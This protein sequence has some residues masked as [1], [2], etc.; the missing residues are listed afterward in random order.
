MGAAEEQAGEFRVQLT[1]LRDKVGRPSYQKLAACAGRL[2]EELPKSTLSDLL[3]GRG[4]PLFSTVT[5]FLQACKAH[6]KEDLPAELFDETRWQREYDRCW[7]RADSSTRSSDGVLAWPVEDFS[8]GAAGIHRAVRHASSA[9]PP[10]LP[11]YVPREHDA[12]LRERL[13]AAVADGGG[14]VLVTGT[15][16]AGKTRSAWEAI[17]TSAFD[18][19]QVVRPRSTEQL[20]TLADSGALR[21]RTVVWLDELQRYLAE[22][23][24]HELADEDLLL[25]WSRHTPVVVIGTLWP[26]IYDEILTGDGGGSGERDGTARSVLK[27]AGEP[28]RVPDRLGDAEL[29]RARR[30]AAGDP[31]LAEALADED[32]GMTQVLA[33]APWL[34]QRWAQPRFAHTRC[35]LAAAAAVRRLDV[36]VPLS[37]TVL[38]EAARG[39]FPDRRPAPRDWF[40]QALAE[41]EQPIRDA[42][43]AL[44][45]ERGPDDDEQAV[46]YT[47]AD[48]LTQHLANGAGVEPIP[49]EV[50]RALSTH[51][52]DPDE[53]FGLARKASSRTL[54]SFAERLYRKALAAGHERASWELT[55]L[56]ADRLC[57]DEAIEEA[58]RADDASRHTLVSLLREAGRVDELRVLAESDVFAR[59][60]LDWALAEHGSVADLMSLARDPEKREVHMT[61]VGRLAERREIDSLRLLAAAGDSWALCRAAD[62]LMADSR[63]A[64]AIEL[65]REHDPERRRVQTLCQALVLDG[66]AAEAVDELRESSPVDLIALL[67]H[68]RQFDELR[69]LAGSDTPTAD[70]EFVN[71]ARIALARVLHGENRTD[72]AIAL[73]RGTTGVPDPYGHRSLLLAELLADAGQVDDALIELRRIDDDPLSWGRHRNMAVAARLLAGAGRHDELRQLADEGWPVAN[74]E[75]GKL[76]R[77]VGQVDEAAK[78]FAHAISGAEYEALVDLALL[79]TD[80]DGLEE[81][82][83]FLAAHVEGQ[84]WIGFDYRKRLAKHLA[85]QDRVDDLR[86]ASTAGKAHAEHFLAALLAFHHAPSK[87]ARDAVSDDGP[88]LQALRL[89][90]VCGFLAHATELRRFGLTP[91]GDI[92]LD[93]D[94]TRSVT[95]ELIRKPRREELILFAESAW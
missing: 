27:L 20:R 73:L 38:R 95:P 42:V 3:N 46:G 66:R 94:G 86:Q 48:Y 25:L 92:A 32:H 67:V 17:R 54:Y 50:W 9:S 62:V 2:G 23:R 30:L 71:D 69:A 31:Y 56:L 11:S 39:Y 55:G 80:H 78:R 91:S 65:L 10:G 83:S 12:E 82:H 60:Q 40:R 51:L 77:D 79:V 19:W 41:A 35:L 18:G 26:D 75:L 47:L 84:P 34:V 29:G 58:R 90:A 45:P 64:D 57:F 72:D 16:C 59:G 37:A 93:A 76:L 81:H 24:H 21:G 89:L 70:P 68:L 14:V 49:A 13:A 6:A 53:L 1:T 15:S 87:L 4:R 74:H 22:R 7:P 5:T 43:S 63:F 52:T 44:V 8:P 28:V 85:E 61:A 36:H 88:S 33:G